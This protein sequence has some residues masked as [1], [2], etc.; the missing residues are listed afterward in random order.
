MQLITN[1]RFP[2]YLMNSEEIIQKKKELKKTYSKEIKKR[3]IQFTPIEFD[4]QFPGEDDIKTVMGEA[5]VRRDSENKFKFNTQLIL[6]NTDHFEK[7]SKFN[8]NNDMIREK[9]HKLD[10][11]IRELFKNDQE[12][13]SSEVDTFVKIKKEIVKRGK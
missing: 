10:D 9:H 12:Y 2:I 11:G 13:D 6:I 5:I 4:F 7:E 1:N 3:N 8:K